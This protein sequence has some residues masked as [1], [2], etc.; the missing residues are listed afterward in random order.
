MASFKEF[1]RRVDLLWKNKCGSLLHNPQHLHLSWGT[2][3]QHPGPWDWHQ[4][5]AHLGTAEFS[6]RGIHAKG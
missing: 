4:N 6:L 2:G 3:T 1:A 5:K